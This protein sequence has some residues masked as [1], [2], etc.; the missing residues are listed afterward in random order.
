MMADASPAQR[1]GSAFMFLFFNKLASMRALF[2]LGMLIAYL[3]CRAHFGRP[4]KLVEYMHLGNSG[5]L[6]GK[7]NYPG[8]EY[9]CPYFGQKYVRNSHW[10]GKVVEI[11]SKKCAYGG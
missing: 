3:T 10:L 11:Y 8:R 1:A 2:I 4:H 7:E 5:P 6:T 9:I